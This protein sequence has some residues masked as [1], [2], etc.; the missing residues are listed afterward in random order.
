MA[1]NVALALGVVFFTCLTPIAITDFWWQ[2]KT[3][4]LIVRT[5]SIPTRDPFSWTAAGQPWLVHEWLTEVFFYLAYTQ[6]PHGALLGYKCGLAAL[7]GGLVL[8][9]AWARSGSLM[10][11]VAAAVSAGFVM[12]NYADLRPQMVTFVLLAALL[13]LL[14]EY[15]EGRTPGIRRALPWALPVVFTL[16]ANLHGGVIVGLILISAWVAGE[17]LARWLYGTAL[18]PIRPLALGLAAS[19]LSV[20]LNPNGFRIYS[21]PFQVL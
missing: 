16:W 10:L 21:Y 18:I 20:A 8:A 12:R 7:A 11:G 15:R 9:R 2:A 5:G 13:L 17:A 14:D 3:G 19:A 1:A 6:A 4:E